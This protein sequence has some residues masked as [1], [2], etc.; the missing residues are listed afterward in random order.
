[1]SGRIWAQVAGICAFLLVGGGIVWSGAPDEG[2]ASNGEIVF[3]MKYVGLTGAKKDGDVEPWIGCYRAAG[4]AQEARSPFTK[5]LNLPRE[6]GMEAM[7]LSLPSIRTSDGNGKEWVALETDGVRSGVLYMDLDGNGKL[8]PNEKILPHKRIYSTEAGPKGAEF[9]YATPDFQAKTKDGKVFNHRLVLTDEIHEVDGAKARHTIMF[10][11]ACV[12]EGGGSI[13]GKAFHLLLLDADRDGR[14]TV[15]GQDTCKFLPE[16][17]YLKPLEKGYITEFLQMM[18]AGHFVC[19]PLSQ[20]VFVEQQFY[21]FRVETAANGVEPARVV[22]RESELPLSELVLELKGTQEVKA[23]LS[24]VSVRRGNEVFLDLTGQEGQGHALPIG[25]YQVREGSIRYGFAKSDEWRVGFQGGPEISAD[26][27][28]T[29]FIVRLGEPKLT[30]A[31]V[32]QEDR[33]SSGTV[34]VRTFRKGDEIW[35]A[36]EIKGLAGEKYLGFSYCE[37]AVGRAP[38]PLISILDANGKEVACATMPYG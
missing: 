5:S 29:P 33:F 25:S 21:A 31:L 28:G 4:T 9:C 24:A 15:Y 3:E 37:P 26:G 34:P 20:L 1:M 23:E 11:P 12:W 17:D 16:A 7:Y 18:V 10:T 14:F 27:A 30:P 8:S 38:D 13:A 36:P 2:K 6:K 32:K 35:C 22:L 19:E